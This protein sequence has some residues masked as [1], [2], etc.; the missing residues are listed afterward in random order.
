MYL[1]RLLLFHLL[2]VLSTPFSST[3]VSSTPAIVCQYFML[4]T[5]S[6]FMVLGSVVQTLISK[7]ARAKSDILNILYN[8]R[9][10]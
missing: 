7:V 8:T 4:V 9:I 6:T 1:V 3:P 5:V 2:L 10:S